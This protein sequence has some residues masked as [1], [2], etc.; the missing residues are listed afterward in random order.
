MSRKAI[1]DEKQ[2]RRQHWAWYM[3]DFGNSAYASVILLAVYATYFKNVVVGGAA[4][5]RLWGFAIGSA[6]LVVEVL[7]PVLGALA[8]FAAHKKRLLFL[9]RTIRMPRF[10]W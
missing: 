6:I 3:Y 4:G 2:R 8:D 9:F 5:S 7:S 10:G 1:S